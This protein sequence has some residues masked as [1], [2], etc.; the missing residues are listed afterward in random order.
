MNVFKKPA[1]SICRV[2]EDETEKLDVASHCGAW[3]VY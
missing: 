3:T 2:E 1:P